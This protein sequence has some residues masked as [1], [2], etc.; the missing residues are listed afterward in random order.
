LQPPPHTRRQV[1]LAHYFVLL[2]IVVHAFE[3]QKRLIFHPMD[4]GLN[5]NVCFTQPL[6]MH[7]FLLHPILSGNCYT[8]NENGI[9]FAIN[10]LVFLKPTLQVFIFN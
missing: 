1:L 5:G 7:Q 10:Q 3:V 2:L 8:M 4:I 6:G 9:A